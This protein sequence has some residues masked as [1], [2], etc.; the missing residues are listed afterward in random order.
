MPACRARQC[1]GK[2]LSEV[3]SPEECAALRDQIEAALRG[4]AGTLKH[5]T[6]PRRTAR[7]TGRITSCRN[8][9]RAPTADGEV[10][11]FFC[12]SYDL[13]EIKRLEA[14]LLQ[15]QKMEA[16]GQL[17]GG[18]AHDFNNLLGVVLGNLQLLERSLGDNSRVCRAKCTRRCAR[19][20][21]AQ[22]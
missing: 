22:T 18:I 1:I 8:S 15:A 3:F 9:R 10:R 17:T 4:E 20:C 16:I 7:A 19:P 11:G 5:S 13:T 6:N 21:V 12:I 2:P 14:R